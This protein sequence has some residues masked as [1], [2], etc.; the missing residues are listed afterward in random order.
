MFS[1][2]DMGMLDRVIKY[3]ASHGI[4]QLSLDAALLP[5]DFDLISTCYQSLKV[6]EL[7]QSQ[8]DS[9]AFGLLSCLKMLDTLTISISFF[10]LSGVEGPHDPFAAFSKLE[11]LNYLIAIL[12]GTRRGSV[13]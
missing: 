13:C 5:G 6:L 4:Q 10:D 2:T 7:Q 12:V 9:T 3:A 8:L 11:N 1:D